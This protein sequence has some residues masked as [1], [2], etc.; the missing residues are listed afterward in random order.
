M[1]SPIT[2]PSL[3]QQF[4]QIQHRHVQP[5]VASGRATLLGAMPASQ[6]MHIAIMLPLRNQTQLTTLLD[7]LYQPSSPNFRKFLTVEQF[8]EQFGPTSEDFQAVINFAKANGLTVTNTPVNRLIVE[9]DGTA[10]QMSAAFHVT[11]NVYQHPTEGRTFYSPDREPSTSLSIPLWYIAGL[12]SYSIPKP[13]Y[14]KAAS[15]AV[16]SNATGSYPGGNYLGSDRRAAYY[17]G[18]AL[19]GAGQTIGLFELDGYNQSD[20]TAYFTNVNQ[21]LNVPVTP[22]ALL[23]ASAT[24]DGND[25]EQ[26]IDIIDA[27]SMAPSL[28]QVLV[29]IAPESGFSSGTGD[30]AIFSKMANDNIA[31][32]IS[33]SWGWQP[34]DYQKNDTILQQL[35]AQGQ[36]VFV[37]AGDS[38]A[39][40]SGSF[41][42]PAEDQYVTAVGGTN[43]ITNGAGGS[44]A[45]ETAWGSNSNVCSTVNNP[46]PGSGGG[47]NLDSIPIPPYQQLSGVINASNQGSTTLRNAPD[48]AAEANCDNYYCADGACQPGLGGT[49]L[50]APTWA[51]FTALVNQ[52]AA[53]N[54]KENLGSINNAVYPIGVGSN[55]NNDFHDITVGN[56]FSATSPSLYSAVTGYD[57]VTGWGSPNGQ[58]LI[59]DLVAPIQSVAAA[60]VFSN[61]SVQNT[62]AAYAPALTYT[63]Y[64]GDSTPGATIHYTVSLCGQT[65]TTNGMFTLS[66]GTPN[67]SQLVFQCSDSSGRDDAIASA[68]ATVPNYAQSPQSGATF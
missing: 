46:Y 58:N 13:L 2:V 32:Q 43:L 66:A 21:P 63:I 11:M 25:T 40:V 38:S 33:V 22:I 60:P 57:L 1:L 3:A 10:A 30:V 35:A 44:W 36:S 56:N 8:T 51:G 9:A 15:S 41:V 62:G 17:G 4:P 34:A 18:T 65:Y 6:Q 37:A 23:G 42:Y 45:S 7:S 68:F 31:K 29:Y 59:N 50:A 26:V 49:S 5:V 27:I 53:L 55:Y 24:S 52:Q 12:D 19:T 14:Q 54:S 61:I 64:L 47:I 67:P 16:K 28:D 20:I 39:W 48:V